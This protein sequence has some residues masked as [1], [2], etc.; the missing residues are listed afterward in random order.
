MCSFLSVTT[1]LF[2]TSHKTIQKKKSELN[3]YVLKII[4]HCYAAI[5]FTYSENKE[6]G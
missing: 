6:S 3:L 5:C 2:E 4:L 1:K